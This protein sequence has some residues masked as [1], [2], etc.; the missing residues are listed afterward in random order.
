[1][2]CMCVLPVE[3]LQRQTFQIVSEDD[4]SDRR[5]QTVTLCNTLASSSAAQSSGPT[6]VQYTQG[7]DG[8]YFI[9]GLCVCLNLI[10][11]KMS[12]VV[13]CK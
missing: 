10:M 8:Q 5:L 13:S 2:L 12:M 7:P 9:P 6:I 4:S 11:L 3:G 1:M